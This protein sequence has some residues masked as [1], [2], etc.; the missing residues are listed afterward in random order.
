MIIN[1]KTEEL[2]QEYKK[3]LEQINKKYENYSIEKIIQT[4]L[5]SHLDM[6]PIK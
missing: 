2:I 3:E 4:L 1:K 5:I 6:K